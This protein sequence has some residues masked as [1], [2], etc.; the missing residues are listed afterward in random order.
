MTK[1]RKEELQL[2]HQKSKERRAE[3]DGLVASKITKIPGTPQA[4]LDSRRQLFVGDKEVPVRGDAIVFLL[5]EG[6]TN[7][8]VLAAIAATKRR[9]S[10]IIESG[11][12][13][14][15]YI[16]IS[17][18]HL[19]F[20]GT[21]APSSIPQYLEKKLK[22]TPQMVEEIGGILQEFT[23]EA[24]T[25]KAKECKMNP[26]GHIVMRFE[27]NEKEKLLGVRAKIAQALS[28][29]G[30]P[31]NLYDRYKDDPQ[32]LEK[33]TTLASVMFAVDF[34]ALTEIQ[35]DQIKT[36]LQNLNA[37]L[38]EFGNIDL[39]SVAWKEYGVRNLSEEDTFR[40]RKYDAGVITDEEMAGS[41][42]GKGSH[43]AQQLLHKD[44]H[45]DH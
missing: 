45:R 14:I 6:S 40:T 19:S 2:E 23:N 4:T 31:E 1:T 20:A 37:R 16:E 43:F 3:L 39:N 5:Q 10:D 11:D 44:I 29:E 30:A 9:I 33:Q 26:D 34:D 13:A 35:K 27:I 32:T 25:C 24:I 8:E 17:Y 12:S 36:E 7:D 28:P 18:P 22:Q 41:S 42:F 21:V 38:Q 15:D